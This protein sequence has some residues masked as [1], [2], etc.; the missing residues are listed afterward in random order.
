MVRIN[1][2]ISISVFVLSIGFS[3]TTTQ[4]VGATQLIQVTAGKSTKIVIND[5]HLL[6][7]RYARIQRKTAK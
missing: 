5:R 7:T 6:S 1:N 3:L 4:A 2:V